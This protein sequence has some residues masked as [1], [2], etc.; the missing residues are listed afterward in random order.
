MNPDQRERN[1]RA[2]IEIA[3]YC[4]THATTIT[5]HIDLMR[6]GHPHA[7]NLEPGHGTPASTVPLRLHPNTGNPTPNHAEQHR[8]DFDQAI[9]MAS[10]AAVA[11]GA[12]AHR[13]A[14]VETITPTES[15]AGTCPP[16]WCRSHYRFG[17]HHEPIALG[18]RYKDLC[19][20]CGEFNAQWKTLP[21]LDLLEDIKIHG[22]RRMD[23]WNAIGLRVTP[24]GKK[25]KKAS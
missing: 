11:L 7:A 6:D 14:P 1:L 18:N 17:Q 15:N 10:R 23:V 19:R 22:K 2:V 4:R 8:R 12:I 21:P 3:T 24:K 25:G 13:Y 20:N 5:N 16:G 9:D